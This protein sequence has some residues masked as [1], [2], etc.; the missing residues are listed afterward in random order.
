MLLP[1]KLLDG[2]VELPC[3]G[4]PEI[5]RLEVEDMLTAGKLV[6]LLLE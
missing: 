1:D 6:L 5:H 3:L 4:Q 2:V